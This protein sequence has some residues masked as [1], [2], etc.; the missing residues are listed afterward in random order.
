MLIINL[1][2]VSAGG[3]LQNAFSFLEELKRQGVSLTCYI[4]YVRENSE[5]E[6]FCIN[7]GL[8]YKSFK[9]GKIGRIIYELFTFKFQTKNYD[10]L[11]IF[12]LFGNC[13]FNSPKK[14]IKISGFARSNIL[15]SDIDFWDFLPQNKK[16]IKK[17]NDKI[18]LFLMRKS[19]SV[20]LETPRL[21]NIALKS[22]CFRDAKIFLV[23][24]SPSSYIVDKLFK[25]PKL[26]VEIKNNV[27]ILYIAGPHPNKNIHKLAKFFSILNRG[28]KNF[29]LQ[30]TLESSTYLSSI[31]EVFAQYNITDK[32]ECIGSLKQHEVP[33]AIAHADALINVAQLESFS[34]NWV[35]A[36]A[37]GRLLIARDASYAKDSCGD[38]AVY[39]D[40]D[41]PRDGAKA[42]AEAF[43]NQ[44]IYDGYTTCGYKK[45]DQLPTASEKYALYMEVINENL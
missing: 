24:M 22:K 33:D 3:G 17:I 15:E 41:N 25:V 18:I 16:I 5:L 12:T 43:E 38:S 31:L 21:V 37:S 2:P 34:N 32:I 29:I 19:H 10:T 28:E 40:L 13:P 26:N 36:W 42:V 39:I 9:T 4:I 44:F 6:L 23:S 45:L 14:A 27:R 30:V 35:E 8:N 20:V 7:N 1:Y 11:I